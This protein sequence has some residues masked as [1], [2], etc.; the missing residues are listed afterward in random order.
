VYKETNAADVY[1]LVGTVAY[2]QD[3]IFTD[4]NSNSAVQASRYKLAII[5]TC[6][7]ESSR[8]P[9]HK[10]IHLTS[11]VGLNNTVNLIWTA[12]EGF[13]FA[14]YNI[15]RGTDINNM[16]LLT[17]IASNLTSY[18]DVSPI[19]GNAFY[20]IE[21]EG[22]SCDPARSAVSSRS[23]MIQHTAS[24]VEERAS[25]M[26]RVYPNPATDQITIQC[27][28]SLIG[29]EYVIYNVVGEVVM[30]GKVYSSAMTLDIASLASG[31]YAFK[32]GAVNRLFVKK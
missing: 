22:I 12:Y 15:Y 19:G 21:V 8:S 26:L 4:V 6:S 32:S 3:G 31:T 29:Q 23:N 10:T 9:L 13:G 11:N 16:T 5:D 17:T 20:V 2:G 24:G 25:Q 18:T 30:R 7:V 27:A 28:S 14:S 1:A